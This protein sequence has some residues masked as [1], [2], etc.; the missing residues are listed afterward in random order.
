MRQ[1][2]TYV[3]KMNRKILSPAPNLDLF[4]PVIQF[5]HPIF[6]NDNC[7]FSSMSGYSELIL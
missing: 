1:R 4:K 7:K 3:A 2:S 6:K 5:Y